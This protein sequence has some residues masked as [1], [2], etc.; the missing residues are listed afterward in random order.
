MNLTAIAHAELLAE[1][2]TLRAQG[3][4]PRPTIGIIRETVESVRRILEGAS[5]N[6]LATFG[7]Q[8]AALL[9]AIPH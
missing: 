9:G 2:H 5:G 1:L 3:T 4:S 7:P 6:M 8:I